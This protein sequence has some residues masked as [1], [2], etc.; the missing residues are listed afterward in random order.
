[1]KY[2]H[3]P[4][5]EVSARG[6]Y[7]TLPDLRS[8]N[9]NEENTPWCYTTDENKRY[10]SCAINKCQCGKT[11][12]TYIGRGDSNNPVPSNLNFLLSDSG[13]AKFAEL[14]P[15]W[16]EN[17]PC[18]KAVCRDMW[19]VNKNRTRR[20]PQDSSS[21]DYS[22]YDVCESATRKECEKE[23][24]EYDEYDETCTAKL[25]RKG[26]TNAKIQQRVINGATY[27]A[28]TTP[29]LVALDYKPEKEVAPVN[30]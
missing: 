19:N 2:P 22:S 30:G 15:F 26:S 17:K 25:D 3:K 20:S 4:S 6:N 5:I 1:M 23:C 24:P 9:C 11:G 18:D 8:L 21:Y 13:S 27:V 14:I 28:G 12:L 29:W 7:C 10:E 16:N